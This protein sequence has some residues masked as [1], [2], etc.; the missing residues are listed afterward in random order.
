VVLAQHPALA[1]EGVLVQVEM[2][3]QRE[4]HEPSCGT[5]KR[6]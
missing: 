6:S 1:V 4:G 2:V 5:E 3:S